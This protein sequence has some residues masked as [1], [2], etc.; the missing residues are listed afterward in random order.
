MGARIETLEVEI[1]TFKRLT[2]HHKELSST[3][4]LS[5]DEILK[6]NKCMGSLNN[7]LNTLE[8]NKVCQESE[9]TDEE[10]E[11]PLHAFRSGFN[12]DLIKKVDEMMEI[13]LEN[14]KHLAKK[15]RNMRPK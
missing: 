3:V 9:D 11:T 15:Q 12:T 2:K 7:L 6:M 1:E 5:M 4:Q 14:A 10:L 13:E 8:I